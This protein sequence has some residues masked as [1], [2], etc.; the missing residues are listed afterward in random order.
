MT[1][2]FFDDF[3]L[4]DFTRWTGTGGAPSIQSVI[5]HGGTHAMLVSLAGSFAYWLD[6]GV[7]HSDTFARFYIYVNVFPTATNFGNVSNMSDSA[8]ATTVSV[9]VYDDGSV[10]LNAPSGSYDSGID[11]AADTWYCIEYERKVGAGNGFAKLW[12]NGNLYVDQ[13]TETITGALY[14]FDLG[15]TGSS[16]SHAT[17][18]FDDVVVADERIFCIG[19]PA[20]GTF[21]TCLWKT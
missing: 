14:E 17:I 2:L 5:V 7:S 20:S 3:E 19:T 13:Q 4:D 8:Y 18:Y 10:F 21:L 12:I 6:D 16:T 11:L 1:V 9:R 15:L